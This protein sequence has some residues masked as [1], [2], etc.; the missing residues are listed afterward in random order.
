MA[1]TGSA[2]AMPYGE[3]TYKIREPGPYWPDT[4][5]AQITS[6][7]GSVEFESFLAKR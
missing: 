2:W 3:V 1:E 7:P 5:Q 6:I 4:G